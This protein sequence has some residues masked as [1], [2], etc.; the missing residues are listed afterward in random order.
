VLL[1]PPDHWRAVYS[2]MGFRTDPGVLHGHEYW[3]GHTL[4]GLTHRNN[5]CPIRRSHRDDVHSQGWTFY[6]EELPVAL[7]FPFVRG[8]RARELVYVNILQRAERISL[9]LKV[10]SGELAPEAAMKA[11]RANV[12]PLGAAFGVRSEEAFEEIEGILQRGLDHCQTGKLQIFKL[13]ADRRMQLGD[14][15]D[16]RQFHDEI[17][18]R[19]SLPIALLRWELTGLDDEVKQLWEAKPMRLTSAH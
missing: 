19:G 2:N 18:Q 13:M 8:P 3:P 10:L 15:F 4:E 7:D 12:P 6:N 17:L 11:M 1:V 16:L 9:G 5:P 14:Q